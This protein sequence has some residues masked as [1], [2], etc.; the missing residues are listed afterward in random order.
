MLFAGLAGLVA[1]AISVAPADGCPNAEP[2]EDELARLGALAAL[3]QVGTAEVAT[4]GGE[5]HITIRD[6]QGMVLGGRAVDA[7]EEC[8]ARAA[9]AAVLIA[10]WTGHWM[11]TNLGRT[12]P[13]GAAAAVPWAA[14]P[15]LTPGTAVSPLPPSSVAAGT[16]RPATTSAAGTAAAP[17]LATSAQPS[18]ASTR[19]PPASATRAPLPEAS[20][21]KPSPAAAL[22]LHV[23]LAVLGL[24]LH[25]GDAGT[26]AGGVEGALLR[27]A[28]LIVGLV[29]AAGE[30]QRSL[31]PGQAGYGFVRMGIGLGVRKGWQRAFV[32]VALVPELARHTLRGIG[33]LQSNSLTAWGFEVDG[34]ARLGWRFGRV[35]PFLF[36]GASWSLLDERLR[37]D[38]PP[39]SITL[40]RANLAAGLGI[41]VVIR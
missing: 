27:R 11:K 34:R 19:A 24:G 21:A 16:A 40:S 6:R 33:F 10:A 17:A 3:T 29:E 1:G 14:P 15:A 13:L 35:A 31:G 5:L 26:F 8:P 7:P 2:I 28:L 4:A 25:D 32:D 9:L 22:P 37:L 12:G 36:L 30:R 41:S 20:L 23:E 18:L 39:A 38:D